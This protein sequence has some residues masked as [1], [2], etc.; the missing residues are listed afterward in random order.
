M[1]AMREYPHDVMPLY[2][3]GF[4]LARYL[5]SQGGKR[6]FLDYIAD[7]LRDENWTRATKQHYGYEN[8]LA[9]Q[10]SWLDWVR[11][12]SPALDATADTPPLVA[13]NAPR[14][15][16]SDAAQ[17][18]V[19][20]PGPSAETLASADG[21]PSVYDVA[22]RG[23]AALPAPRGGDSA[24]RLR[25]SSAANDLAAAEPATSAATA[26]PIVQPRSGPQYQVTRPQ[27]IQ[28]PRQVILEWNRPPGGPPGADNGNTTTAGRPLPAPR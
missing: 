28:R 7:G 27:D 2:S 26:D 4:S 24:W 1:F 22:A 13:V 20:A 12:G 16:P 23:E 10:N 18:D 11:K 17:A 19:A 15:G 6:K 3:Q 8:L 9:L 5:V 25:G 14:P 21:Q